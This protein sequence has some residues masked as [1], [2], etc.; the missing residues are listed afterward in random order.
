MLSV[1]SD[2]EPLEHLTAAPAFG[3]SSAYLEMVVAMAMMRAR[4]RARVREVVDVVIQL[5]SW[6]EAML[7]AWV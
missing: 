6:V 2:K 7:Q 4:A 3:S 1:A 5:A